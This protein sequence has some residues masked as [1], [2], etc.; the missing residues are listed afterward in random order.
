MRA[1]VIPAFNEEETILEVVQFAYKF[2]SLVVVV[3]D[4]SS[5]LT[6][7]IASRAG[8]VVITHTTNRGYESSIFSGIQ[9]SINN[10]AKSVMT[11]DADGQHQFV[12]CNK[13]FELIEQ[14]RA[15]MVIGVRHEIPRLMENIISV[16]TTIFLGVSDIASG[17][18]CYSIDV[19]DYPQ[20]FEF[21]NTLAIKFVINA[22]LSRKFIY[23]VPIEII[24]RSDE[25]RY[26]NRFRGN[27]KFTYS[28]IRLMYWSIFTALPSKL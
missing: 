11:I 10:K 1:I 28:I 16:F 25:S 12:D 2:A 7:D 24:E 26:G 23:Q 8:A 6:A 5:D 20:S 9:Y 22:L 18:K 21:T 27:I 3:D 17:C 15:D 13:F 4:C 19:F 14:N